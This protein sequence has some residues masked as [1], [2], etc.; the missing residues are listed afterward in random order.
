MIAVTGVVRG[1]RIFRGREQRIPWQRETIFCGLF[2]A[3]FCALM[4]TQ[5]KLVWNIR[6]LIP[7][8]P[9]VYILIAQNL[10]TL[11]FSAAKVESSGVAPLSSM[12][13]TSS[14][15]RKPLGQWFYNVNLAVPILMLVMIVELVH[16][17]P[18]HFSYIN[19]LFGGSYHTPPA[20]NDSNFDYGQDLFTI[21]PWLKKQKR[22]AD[23]S[24][25]G[26]VYGLLSGHGRRWLKEETIPASQ[27]V[28]QQAIASR[29]HPPQQSSDR[30]GHAI[31]IISRGL[32]N[33]EPWA[34]RYSTIA[35]ENLT[36]DSTHLA[37]ELLKHK[38]DV[39]IT[40]TIAVYYFESP[41]NAKQ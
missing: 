7:A 37:E 41:S 23:G 38:P 33:G 29:A 22:L 15:G 5:S 28:L 26:P 4:A 36:P 20:L 35:D 6:Y 31:L 30:T 40:P 13:S 8:L 19:P 2:L 17:A 32:G 9:L 16:V 34:I 39:F 14:A 27:A 18:F 24:S 10:P 12:V 25:I 11:T 21:P 1:V 3:C